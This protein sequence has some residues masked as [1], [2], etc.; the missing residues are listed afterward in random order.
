ML[1]DTVQVMALP[2]LLLDIY[3]SAKV[4]GFVVIFIVAFEISIRPFIG[5]IA[6]R[7]NRKK[8][9]IY[10][11]FINGALCIDLTLL[12][13]ITTLNLAVILIYLVF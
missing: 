1:G 12:A 2:L 6:D 9:M 4:M 8:L 7:K 5:V 3:N 13:Y 11:D 10:S